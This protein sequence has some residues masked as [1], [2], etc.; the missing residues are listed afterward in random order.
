MTMKNIRFFLPIIIFSFFYHAAISQPGAEIEVQKPTK[1]ENRK[2][3]SEKTGEKKLSLPKRFYQNTVTH[4]NYFF[5]AN[6][7]LNDLVEVAKSGFKDDYS[8]LLPFYNYT[9]EATSQNKTE[10][11]SIV[12]KCTAGILLHDLRN[13]W[14]DNL[15][16]ILAKAYF[17]RN[18]LDSAGLTLQYINF[19]FAPKEAGGYDIPIGSN[20]SNSTG[21]FTISTK[22]KNSF[23]KKVLSRPPSRNESF[24]W[25]IRTLIENKELGEAA[26]IMEILRS[27]PNFPKRLQKDLHEQLAFWFYKQQVYDS[28]AHHLTLALSNAKGMQEQA[29]WEFLIAQMYQLAKNPSASAKYYSLA[30][31]HTID[32]VMDVYARLSS[33]R[34][35]NS[36]K[37]ENLQENIDALLAM[38]K[39]DKYSAYR[40]IIYYAIA[41]IEIERKNFAGA[42]KSL[43]KSVEYTAN[44]PAQR[45]QAFLLLADMNYDQHSYIEA[46]RFYDSLDESQLT[47]QLEKDRVALRKPFLKTIAENIQTIKEQDSLQALA[48]LTPEQR[49]AFIKK[50]KKANKGKD[51]KEE[52]KPS[53]NTAVVQETTDLFSSSTGG[54]DFYFYNSS[55]KS[56]GFSEF[57]TKWG[58]RPN[59]DNWRRKSAIDKMSSKFTD[60]DDVVET[61][62]EKGKDGQ[63]DTA[64]LALGNTIPVTPDELKRSNGAIEDAL[65]TNGGIFLN[66]LEELP[67]AIEAY[68]E[69]LRRFPLSKYKAEAL[70]N[71]MY[72]YQKTGDKTK[73]DQCKNLLLKDTADSKYSTL[74]KSPD[75]GNTIGK[76]SP[77]TKKYEEIYNLFIEG[78]F[79]QAVEEKRVADSMYSKSNWTPQLLFIEAI[80]YIKQQNDST[81]IKVLTDLT[82]LFPSNPMAEKA[83]TMI[84]VLSR[85]KEIEEYLSKLDVKRSADGTISKGNFESTPKPVKTIIRKVVTDSTALTKAEPKKEEKPKELIN[86]DTTDSKTKDVTT[87]DSNN[88]NPVDT[89]TEKTS[90]D[91]PDVALTDSTTEIQPVMDDTSTNSNQGQPV[92][93]TTKTY[94][95]NPSEPQ[96]VV[97]ILDKVDPVYATEARNAFDRF[98][99]Q[100]FYNQTISVS[101]VKVDERYHLILQGPFTDAAAAIAYIDE[102]KPITTRGILPWLSAE[103]Y[104]F[105]IISDKNLELLKSSKEMDAYKKLIQQAV[106]GKF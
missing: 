57:K 39:K 89:T 92:E 67:G 38:A 18:D 84:D 55:L 68:E 101:G 61:G 33:L 70:F 52:D 16:L 27:D 15:Y 95:Y 43:L 46:H 99:K 34:L 24:I 59:V 58:D 1:Y 20:A 69:L 83:K 44:N 86:K 35:G 66:K 77:A 42:Q 50:Q 94:N 85:R 12:Y 60:V 90:M 63:T 45:T 5:N 103:K 105:F 54:N 73:S 91:N 102:V 64:S 87:I 98:N 6:A 74:I 79:L 25:Q 56:R 71:L 23:I 31:K 13:D 97:T 19:A 40:D 8:Q 80:Y 26:G 78:N 53:Y 76:V 47:K 22:E 9:L 2:L 7:R 62:G 100:K 17:F 106:P 96:Y 29:R 51:S 10:L 32:P 21:Q 104:S 11:D 82:T 41:N 36:D 65:A 72:A 37:K 14:I 49:E 75:V 28:A 93:T 48:K 88:D 4:Y 81:A 3:R 30:M